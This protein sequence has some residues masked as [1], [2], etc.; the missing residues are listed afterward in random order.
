M[1]GQF[2]GGGEGSSGRDLRV[3][4]PWLLSACWAHAQ[5]A[6]A[7]VWRTREAEGH[8]AGR[9]PRGAHSWGVGRPQGPCEEAAPPPHCGSSSGTREQGGADTGVSPCAWGP[10]RLRGSVLCPAAPAGQQSGAWPVPRLPAAFRH[11]QGDSRAVPTSPARA[12]FP[13][14]DAGALDAPA[15]SWPVSERGR[16]PRGVPRPTGSR[17]HAEAG[18]V[19]QEPP[20]P[21][22][23]AA[24][25]PRCGE[26]WP[27]GGW[28]G[29]SPLQCPC[30]S[31]QRGRVKR[32]GQAPGGPGHH[33][34]G[35]CRCRNQQCQSPSR[36]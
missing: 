8:C 36:G 12:A 4:W 18:G 23:G 33:K 31:G 32:A 27:E 22:L 19:S 15:L 6:R 21:C 25:E 24:A 3:C 2:L 10:V 29:Q 1:C 26:P 30:P 7:S 34:G 11:S 20:G 13:E 17:T 28:P 35:T 5:D 9:S 14:E 16:V